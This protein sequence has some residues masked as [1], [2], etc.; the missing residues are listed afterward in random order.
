M[1]WHFMGFYDVCKVHGCVIKKQVG[2]GENRANCRKQRNYFA[3][4]FVAK[5]REIC[6]QNF[7][8]IMSQKRCCEDENNV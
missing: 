3:I 2:G 1:S 7:E 5:M 6:F 4:D 8:I